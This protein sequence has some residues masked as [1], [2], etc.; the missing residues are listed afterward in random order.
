[1]NVKWQ[2]LQLPCEGLR[3]LF[4]AISDRSEPYQPCVSGAPERGAVRPG[5]MPGGVFFRAA[6]L[7]GA[8]FGTIAR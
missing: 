1:M 8:T 3:R 4:E 6:T 2:R 7:V 5:V